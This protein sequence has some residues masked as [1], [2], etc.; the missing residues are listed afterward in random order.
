MT[1]VVAT[2]ELHSYIELYALVTSI[3]AWTYSSI[4]TSEMRL[5]ST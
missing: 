1:D 2:L 3:S 4:H 5:L